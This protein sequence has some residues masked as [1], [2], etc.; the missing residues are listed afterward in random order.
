MTSSERARL[1]V[2]ENRRV[3][4]KKYKQSAKGK[5]REKVYEASAK[6]K[7]RHSRSYFNRRVKGQT[8]HEAKCVVKI[9]DPKETTRRLERKKQSNKEAS[10]QFRARW[11][12]LSAN[13]IHRHRWEMIREGVW[14]EEEHPL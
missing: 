5:A 11:G 8:A 10:R 12:H 6:G 1:H 9:G 2:S 13:P 14:K 7:L 4:D 3:A